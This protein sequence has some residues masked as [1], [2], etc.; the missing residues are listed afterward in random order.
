VIFYV[1]FMFDYGTSEQT[2][3]SELELPHFPTIM[4]EVLSLDTWNRF[5]TEGYTYLTIPGQPGCYI[6]FFYCLYICQYICKVTVNTFWILC[7]SL[8]HMLIVTSFAVFLFFLKSSSIIEMCS[9][10]LDKTKF[11]LQIK[12]SI[13][14]PCLQKWK[15]V[16]PQISWGKNGELFVWEI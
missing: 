10:L 4:I 15:L 16:L 9:N 6:T 12:L 7:Y 5:R 8:I 11:K 2:I 13:V 3:I 14:V 1:F